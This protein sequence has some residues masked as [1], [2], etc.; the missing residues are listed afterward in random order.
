M[1]AVE[2]P[3]ASTSVVDGEVNQLLSEM[4][5]VTSCA[6]HQV[7]SRFQK[8]SPHQFHV[9]SHALQCAMREGETSQMEIHPE[10]AHWIAGEFAFDDASKGYED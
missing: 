7:K 4:P 1:A 9:A 8:W 3:D 5:L 6:V 2:P 10:L